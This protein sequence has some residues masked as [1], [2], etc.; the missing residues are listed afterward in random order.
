MHDVRRRV[1]T[2]MLEAGM[3]KTYRDMILGHSLEGMDRHYIKPSE[4][5]LRQ[6]MAR[7]TAWLDEQLENVDHAVDQ[8]A[9]F[10][11]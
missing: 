3:D 9:V 4:E 5:T 6:A 1:K 10:L 7:Y 2:N 11:S 8:P